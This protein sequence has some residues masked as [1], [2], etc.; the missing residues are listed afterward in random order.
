MAGLRLVASGELVPWKCT[1]GNPMGGKTL[2]E[3]IY[4]M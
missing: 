4:G 2:R 3:S 1:D